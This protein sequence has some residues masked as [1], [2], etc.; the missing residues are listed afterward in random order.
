MSGDWIF[1]DHHARPAGS[2]DRCRGPVGFH[3]GAQ[4]ALANLEVWLG[5]T[6][7][8]DAGSRHVFLENRP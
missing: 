2:K 4:R 8:N 3:P 1:R 6:D 5:F 7:L